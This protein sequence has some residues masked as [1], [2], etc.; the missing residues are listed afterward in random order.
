MDDVV[1][2]SSSITSDDPFL[3]NTDVDVSDSDA[4]TPDLSLDTDTSVSSDETPPED[5]KKEADLVVTASTVDVSMEDE[6]VPVVETSIQSIA[7]N[8]EDLKEDVEPLSEKDSPSL[9]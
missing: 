9:D 6:N 8:N 2:T 7:P 3:H 5:E 4:E 1:D